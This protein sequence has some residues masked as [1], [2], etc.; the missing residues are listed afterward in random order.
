MSLSNINSIYHGRKGISVL[1]P[2]IERIVS[3]YFKLLNTV[4]CFKR[5]IKVPKGQSENCPFKNSCS[6]K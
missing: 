2:E 5:A 6:N 4:N 1:G 3:S